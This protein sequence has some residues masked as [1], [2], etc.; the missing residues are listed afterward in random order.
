MRLVTRVLVRLRV[1][2]K[3]GSLLLKRRN[4]A[5]LLSRARSARARDEMWRGDGDV[6]SKDGNDT[7]SQLER[8]REKGQERGKFVCLVH[9]AEN[10]F[11]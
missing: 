1:E 10:F 4:Q 7:N 8:E 6:Y 2:S 9:T 11:D 5:L 3:S